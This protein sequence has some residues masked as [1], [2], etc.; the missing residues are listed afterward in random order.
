MDIT[1]V[2]SFLTSLQQ[3]ILQAL[4]DL[5]PALVEREDRW[6]RPGGGG[7]RSVAVSGN[8]FEKGAVNFSDVHGDTLPPAA[9][10][11]RPQLAG[12]PFR[13]LGVSVVIHP[14]NPFIPTSHMNVRFFRANA[15]EPVWW[16]GGGFDLTPYYPYWSD[17][18]EW[19]RAAEGACKDFGTDLYERFK[20]E[21][22]RYF[23]LPHRQEARGVGGLFFDDFNEDGFEAAF[24]FTRTV[25]ETFVK[26]YTALVRKRM[27]T[28][29]ED[30]HRHF[31][32]YRRGRYVEF[33]LLHDRGTLFGLQSGGRTE[34]ILLSLPPLVRW[35]YNWSPPPGSHEAALQEHFLKPRNWLQEPPPEALLPEAR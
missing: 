5:D 16:F 22:D 14:L 10:K 27:L 26:A 7:G 12:R 17:A 4:S 13:A 8:V 28:P 31:Q 1:A 29:Y 25:G 2:E 6:K 33:N 19:H 23:Y 18:V 30:Q 9:T 21:C 15:D 20:A 3:R 35:D 32:L 11:N 34:S 24:G